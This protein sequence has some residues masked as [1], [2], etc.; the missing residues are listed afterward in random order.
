VKIALIADIHA[1]LQALH[2]V[3]DDIGRWLPDQLVVLGDVIN[4]GPR[5][6]ECLE[7]VLQRQLAAGWL[8]TIGNHEEYVIR[9]CRQPDQT[10]QMR[11]LFLPSRWTGLQIGESGVGAVEQ[12][13]FSVTLPGPEGSEVRGTHASMLH[14]RDG[15]FPDTS[16]AELRAKIGTPQPDVL[17]VGH[18]HVPLVRTLDHALVVNAGAVGMP[19]DGDPRAS[20]AQLEWRAQA[21]HARIVRLDYD[22]GRSERDFVD[23]GFLEEGGELTRVMLWER[24]LARGLLFEWTR[25]YEAAVLDG[26]L[27]VAQSVNEYLRAKGLTEN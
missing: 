6:R 12:W 2:A 21:W 19:F 26:E 14:T 7:F 15:V 20:Y 13:P 3:V 18:T 4:R 8:V 25:D 23:S 9:Q 17:A 24:R 10:E 11:D 5:P 16:D 22:R 1:N 27:T